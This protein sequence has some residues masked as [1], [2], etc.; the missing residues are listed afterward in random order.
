M[1]VLESVIAYGAITMMILM[2]LMFSCYQLFPISLT[3][4][5]FKSRI[6]F[7]FK[8]FVL[9]LLIIASDVHMTQ[10][11]VVFVVI[12]LFVVVPSSPLLYSEIIVIKISFYNLFYKKKKK[13]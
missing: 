4:N 1:D 6:I 5:V 2:M 11:F 3:S 7:S 10:C 8:I 12:F 9:L 13:N